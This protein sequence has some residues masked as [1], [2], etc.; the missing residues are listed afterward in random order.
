MPVPGSPNQPAP[1]AG[2]PREAL[3]VAM[4]QCRGEALPLSRFSARCKAPERLGSPSVPI[5]G[6]AQQLRAETPSRVPAALG[7]AAL[8]AGAGG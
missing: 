7:V 6:L 3:V 8:S 2:R 4:G 5:Y 1:G